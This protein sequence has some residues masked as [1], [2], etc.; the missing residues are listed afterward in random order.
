MSQVSTT[1]A[2]VVPGAAVFG[3]TVVLSATVSDVAPGTGVPT[4]TITFMDGA[5]TLGTVALSGAVASLSVST[6]TVSIHAISAIYSGC[7]NDQ[8]SSSSVSTLTVG[9]AATSVTMQA[10][11]SPVFGQTVTLAASVAPISPGAGMPTGTVIFKDGTATLG[12]GSMASG[13]A[14]FITSSLSVSTHNI[15][16]VYSGDTDFS[17][18]LG[19]QTQAVS[20]AL[21]TTTL[22]LNPTVFGQSAVLTASVAAVSPGAGTPT[23]IVTF[24]DQTTTLGTGILNGSG[25]ATFAFAGLAVGTH[26][27]SAVYSGDVDFLAGAVATGSQV[28]SQA[29]S[30]VALAVSGSTLIGQTE[31]FTATVAVVAPGAGPPTGGVTFL[32]GTTTL[33]TQSISGGTAS[34]QS[35]TLALGTHSITVV[36]SGDSNFAGAASSPSELT[37]NPIG[38]TT[39][40]TVVLSNAPSSVFGQSVTLTASVT[41]GSGTPTGTVAF[42]DGST[43]LGTASLGGGLATY[44]SA[45]FAIGTHLITVTYSGDI[46]FASTQSAPLTQ[47]VSRAATSTSLSSSGSTVFGQTVTLT[48]SVA[49]TPPGLGTPTGAV[50][51]V[52][53][54]STL[55][56]AVLAGTTASLSVSSLS[57]ATHSITAIY[58]GDAQFQTSTSSSITQTVHDASTTTTLT[59]SAAT[60]ALNSGVTFTATVANAGG[61]PGGV[62]TFE[63]GTTTLGTA[64]LNG[65]GVASFTTTLTVGFYNMSN[66]VAIGLDMMPNREYHARSRSATAPRPKKKR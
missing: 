39:D 25:T 56:T 14:T 36:Y 4:G 31:T 3:Q 9:K 7:T 34:F 30:S 21:T 45:S 18:S 42:L 44:Q 29:T 63:S 61:T 11:G 27:I 15:T 38:S 54:T 64:T 35:S 46:N 20:P 23:G 2:L 32:D 26:A 10:L 13:I 53:G 47:I 1:T 50:A 59:L 41:S 16:G 57:A 66:R 22:S 62:V 55:G 48:A 12:T 52:D 43:T 19:S 8:G 5:T 17:S 37:I 28:V 49:V 51:F 6:L 65:S 58:S 24:L 60:V 40:S 33:G